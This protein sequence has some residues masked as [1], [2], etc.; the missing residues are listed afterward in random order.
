VG[1]LAHAQ[2][3]PETAEARRTRDAVKNFIN[4]D[5]T[6]LPVAV[7]P[8]GEPEEE[9][10]GLDL[11]STT[12]TEFG[13]VDGDLTHFFKQ[14]VYGAWHD[15]GW[16]DEYVPNFLLAT[17]NLDTVDLASDGTLY[18]GVEVNGFAR[19]SKGLVFLKENGLYIFDS[20]ARRIH[21]DLDWSDYGLNVHH[22]DAIDKIED[23]HYAFSVSRTYF[24]RH[25]DGWILLEPHAIYEFH[26]EDGIIELLFDP[27]AYFH[28]RNVDALDVF[29]DGRIAF[30]TSASTFFTDDEDVLHRLWPQNAYVYDPEEETLSLAF[31]GGVLKLAD[32]DA[33]SLE[34][35][36]E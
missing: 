33:I 12:S 25:S 13:E 4:Q 23:D 5:R 2:F 3:L 21:E 28:V 20:D 15:D 22:V 10:G 8:S 24:V 16:V 36:R 31:D 14:N 1:S 34:A 19:D 7:S 32:I 6:E 9:E 18:F 26:A 27:G 29:P 30:S 17:T 11:F 35:G